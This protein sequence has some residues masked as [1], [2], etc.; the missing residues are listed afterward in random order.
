MTNVLAIELN[1]LEADP[2]NVRKTYSADGVKQLAA[3]IEANGLLQNL[4]VR[5]GKKGRFLVTAGG[6]RLSALNLLVVTGKIAAD[7]PV[8]CILREA[9]EATEISL[10]ENFAREAMSPIDEY[11]AFIALVD[12]GKPVADIAARFGTTEVMVRKRLALGRVSPVLL[13][14]FR[15]GDMSFAQLSAFTV[16]DDHGEQERVWN[17]LPSYNRYDHTIRNALCE[18]AVKASD[19]RLRFIGGLEAYEAAGGPVKRDLF[20]DRNEG[21]ALD[22]VLLE[23]L[24]AAK[25]QEIADQIKAEGWQWVEIMNEVAWNAFS[26]YGRIYPVEAE[27]SDEDRQQLERLEEEYERLSMLIESGE[28]DDAAEKALDGVKDRIDA[29]NDRPDAYAA[30]DLAKAGAIV[31]LGYYGKAEIARGLIRPEDRQPAQTDSDDEEGRAGVSAENGVTAPARPVLVHSATLIEDLTA[32]KTAAIRAEFATNTHVALAS[33]VHAL[34]LQTLLSYSSDC[35]CLELRLTSQPL[36]NSMKTP[37]SNL[38]LEALASLKERFGDHVPGEPAAIFAWC[39]ERTQEELLDLLAFAASLSINA[40]EFKHT[41]RSQALVHA[42]QLASALKLDM[43]DYFETTAESYFKHLTRDGIEVAVAEAKGDDFAE[44]FSRMKKA[45][46]AAHAENAVK[47]SG[48]LPQP[49]R[50]VTTTP[51]PDADAFDA[52]LIEPTEDEIEAYEFP[53]AA[54]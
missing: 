46:A 6:R 52:A 27:L 23:T 24:V 48:W 43:R 25:L 13:D 22:V 51:A 29:I 45:E 26:T 20:D 2:K 5:K 17:Q 41:G 4:V 16:C 32:Q 38:A 39:L 40:V 18:N 31:S 36:G 44:G 15:K 50:S 7:Y 54:E 19:K 47:G 12:Q 49:L 1:K 42:N 34:L 35:T 8:N 11:E 53:E 21:Y 10:S 3:N 9:D 33:V 28:A 30:A 37:E 14:L